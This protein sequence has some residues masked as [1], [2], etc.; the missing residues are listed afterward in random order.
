MANFNCGY[1]RH[2]GVMAVGMHV[3]KVDHMKASRPSGTAV[4]ANVIG[5]QTGIGKGPEWFDLGTRL[6]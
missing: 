4:S 5:K 1:A 2:L 3:L 6:Q